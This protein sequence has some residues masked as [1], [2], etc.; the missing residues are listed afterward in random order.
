M[1]VPWEKASNNTNQRGQDFS[2]NYSLEKLSVDY[3]VRSRKL[4]DDPT[5]LLGLGRFKN[6]LAHHPEAKEGFGRPGK[7]ATEGEDPLLRI[8]LRPRDLVLCHVKG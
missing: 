6:S 7:G 2:R 4:G 5:L 1:K 3:I 8:N